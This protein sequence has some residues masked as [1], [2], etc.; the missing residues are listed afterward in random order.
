MLLHG[1][2][3]L[4]LL[5]LLASVG[6]SQKSGA[7]PWKMAS[8]HQ[9]LFPTLQLNK[10][11]TS[12]NKNGS[13]KVHHILSRPSLL[14]VRAMLQEFLTKLSDLW[15]EEKTSQPSELSIWQKLAV[16]P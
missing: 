2:H 13:P 4:A 1:N 6:S 7:P 8:R 5:L 15:L 10:G 9:R 11:S 14:V 3:A 12:L 16:G